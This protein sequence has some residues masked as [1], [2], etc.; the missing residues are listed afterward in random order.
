VLGEK[1]VDGVMGGAFDFSIDVVLVPRRKGDLVKLV[2]VAGVAVPDVRVSAEFRLLLQTEQLSATHATA[3]D[4]GRMYRVCPFRRV[5]VQN[6]AVGRAGFAGCVR[7][8]S[9]SSWRWW[10]GRL[11]M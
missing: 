9:P 4:D 6:R 1:V 8:P 11:T 2:V 3:T 7:C 5:T 10:P